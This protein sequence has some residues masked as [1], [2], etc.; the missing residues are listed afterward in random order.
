MASGT[1]ETLEK[2]LKGSEEF[3]ISIRGA[4]KGE[5]RFLSELP[6][7]IKVTLERESGDE[8]DYLV[9]SERGRD[10]RSLLAKCILDS[11]LELLTLKAAEWNL[12][13]I[14]LKIVTQEPEEYE[15]CSES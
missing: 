14:F 4:R 9:V 15:V 5:E 2:R 10:V 6:G 12:E 8:R 13:D 1:A 3:R 11:G 7:V